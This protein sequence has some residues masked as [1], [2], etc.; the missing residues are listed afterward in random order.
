MKVIRL[1]CDTAYIHKHVWRIFKKK[2]ERKEKK[3]VEILERIFD[4]L[5][6]LLFSILY[7]LMV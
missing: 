4:S 1:R 3:C 2:K 7:V 6:L 5:F